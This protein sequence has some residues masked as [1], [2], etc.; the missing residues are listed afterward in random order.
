VATRD[1][2]GQTGSSHPK[3]DNAVVRVVTAVVAIFVEVAFEIIPFL[4]NELDIGSCFSGVLPSQPLSQIFAQFKM[5]C[6][7]T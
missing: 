3:G 4:V 1:D 5:I 6:K 2:L 7:F